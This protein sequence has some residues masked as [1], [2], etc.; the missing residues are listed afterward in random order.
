M[1]TVLQWASN[2]LPMSYAVEAI[3][4]VTT[5]PSLTASYVRGTLVVAGCAVAAL[6]LAATSLRRRTD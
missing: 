3:Q 1:A 2:V 5:Y 4:Q 6:V